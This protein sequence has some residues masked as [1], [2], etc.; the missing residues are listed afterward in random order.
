MTDCL[1]AE[2]KGRVTTSGE[3]GSWPVREKT[4]DLRG[5][6][7]TPP[8]RLGP[9]SGSHVSGP[10]TWMADE[11]VIHTCPAGHHRSP[12]LSEKAAAVGEGI[13]SGHSM[14]AVGKGQEGLLSQTECSFHLGSPAS[15]PRPGGHSGASLACRG[16]S[17]TWAWAYMGHSPT[18]STTCPGSGWGSHRAQELGQV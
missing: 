5:G 18:N 3:T 2:D 15:G 9:P 12:S 14:S 11:D 8:P 10:S 16:P 4:G 6:D 13:C 7:S 1:E 17:V